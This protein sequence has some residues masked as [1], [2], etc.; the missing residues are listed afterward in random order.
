MVQKEKPVKYEAI[1]RVNR[2]NF[3]QLIARHILNSSI[4][5]EELEKIILELENPNRK[6][7]LNIK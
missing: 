3:C 7:I 6:L 1:D 2:W 4:S 5:A